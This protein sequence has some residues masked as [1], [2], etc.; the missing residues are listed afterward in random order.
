MD[1]RVA[2]EV[3]VDEW[4]QGYKR[5][6]EP[7]FLELVNFIVRS[8][9]CRGTVTLAMLREQ[10]NTEIIQ[11]LTETFSEDSSDYPLSLS[12]GPWRR[13]RAS[14]GAVVTAVALRSRHAVLYD[15]FLL[16]GLTA[17]LTSLADSQV[18]AFRHTATLAAMKLMTALVEV[19]LGLSQRRDNTR[20]LYEAERGKSPPRR[21]PGKLEALQ[22]T[23]RE[24]QEQ[25]EEMEAVMNA[26]FKGVFVHRY[27]DV[28]PDVRALCMEEL[29]TWMC[30][31]P[32]SFLTDG[33]L[34]YLGWTLH[35][36]QGEVRLRCVRA[37]QGLYAR[38]DTAAH[39]ELFTGRFKARLVS[40]VQDKDPV[41]AVEVV[42]LLTVMLD[43][44]AEALTEADCH[45]VY[46]AVFC[47]RRP[48][49][50]AAGLFLY[51]SLLSPRHEGDTEPSPG[52]GDNR[53]FFRL[54]LT[55]FIESELHQHA[56]YLVDSLWDCAGTQLRDWDTAGGLLLEEAPEEVP[57]PALS[58]QQE[59]AL[60]EILAASA[61]WAAGEGP[62][63]GRGPPRKAPP[64][65]RR[66]VTE[67]RSRLS[68]CL[69]PILPRLL[70][71][72]S[73]D[74]EKVTPLLEVLS[75]FELSV[76]CTA[77]LE[78]P[79]EQALA[80]LQ[81]LVQK[82]TGPEVLG[83]ASRA[84]GALCDPRLPLRGRGELVRSRLGDLLGERCHRLLR[85]PSLDEEELYS[86]AATLKRL[87]V[88]FNAH[89]LTPWQ[90]F[91]P[92]TLLLRRA[93]DTG[94]V[95]PQLLVP[96]ITCAHFHILWE[97]SR[98][99]NTDV[100]QEQ[101]LSLKDKTT[102]F[103]ALCQSCLSNGDAGVR[104][105]AFVVLSDLLLVLGP[106]GTRRAGAALAPLR[107]V[108]D[109]ELRSQLAAVLLNHVFSP[110]D[111]DG[112][113]PDAA[114]AHM[115]DLR[116]RRML[117]A[118]FCKLIIYN[119]LEP[120]AAS[121]VLKYY[122]KFHAEYGDIIK[123]TLA[124][125]RC[126]DGQEW[127]RVV[128]LSLQQVMTELLMEH[129][130]G[131]RGVP[132]FGG[133]R[134]LGRRLSLFF[135]PRHQPNRQVLLRLH[136]DSIAFALQEGPEGGPGG[137]PGGAPLY[138]PFLEVLSEFSPRLL[139]PDR[140]LLLT[141]LQQSCQQLGMTPPERSPWPPLAAY[142]R[143]LQPPEPP[144]KRRRTEETWQGP[145]PPLSPALTSTVLRAPPGPPWD[146]RVPGP[147]SVVPSLSVMEE[148]EEEEEEEERGG[149][150]SEEPPP[151]LDQVRD[152]FDS[153]ILGI[154]D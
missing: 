54:L 114:E 53:T 1:G 15:G 113:E 42:K 124:C 55:F 106:S 75:C 18:R 33:H 139:P 90:L 44:V 129:G 111:R 39:M 52:S 30:S 26:I 112:D 37:L 88:L 89:D 31:F 110:G 154:E 144:Q 78:R 94:E 12:T 66:A 74:E 72:F 128:L 43:T 28:V 121:D 143:S 109:V 41:V 82:H 116:R 107:L 47:S 98:L 3:A 19:A 81:E 14:F 126:M 45:R 48:L 9:G 103:C 24:L 146:L 140:A 70:A 142:H 56:A 40:M 86:A 104:E 150:S 87:S 34:K 38:R 105:Q 71:K 147:S 149:G 148:E 60:V 69:A 35:D 32:A 16:G 2:I 91:E 65:G 125:I 64:K 62:P 118:G 61:K 20:R 73:A 27:R 25:Q 115:E 117:L 122:D 50:T 83:A 151:Q 7:A 137:D 119:V 10:Q 135:G 80:Q 133:L 17:L 11:R 127:A 13:F 92:C 100:P 95:P 123:E 63:V 21:A 58:D 51:R 136:R 29:G 79:L 130:P 84:L 101:L 153:S 36:K 67:Q 141:H 145:S 97:L 76:Y 6:R 120:S 23:L 22:E 93:A 131:V 57:P 68:L 85:L 132:A 8:C 138:L 134:D 4:L 77:R 96:A 5:D 102:S 152:L 49:A 59:K 46:P 108:P 99:A